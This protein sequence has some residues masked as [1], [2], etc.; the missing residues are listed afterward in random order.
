MA[1]AADGSVWMFGGEFRIR[2]DYLWSGE[3]SD[4]LL[5]LD[6][7]ERRWHN[8]TVSGL[9]PGGRRDHVMA[10]V[11]NGTRLLVFGGCTV[12]GVITFVDSPA[13][14]FDDVWT[15][16]VLNAEWTQ[17]TS[18]RDTWPSARRGHAMATISATRVVVF[19]GQSS[20]GPSDETW[21]F[22]FLNAEW[23]QLTV[24]SSGAW[25]SARHHHAMVAVSDTRVLLFG[26]YNNDHVSS[27]DEL[28]SLDVPRATWTQL[29][30][31][32]SGVCPNG[33]FNHAM[34]AVSDAR[35]PV[36]GVRCR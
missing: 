2:S 31:G 21:I 17:L 13:Q 12:S 14:L 32:A 16:D 20:S 5:K 19:G 24:G 4:E 28:W 33:R 8:M 6:L 9:R 36:W 15:F 7:K 34:V 1:T 18:V 29:M 10:A 27:S 26:G 30:T 25:P 22:E 23:T 11:A 3:W 35:A